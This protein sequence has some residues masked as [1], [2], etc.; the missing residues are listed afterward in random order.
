ME[1]TSRLNEDH[2]ALEKH[3][4]AP[5]TAICIRMN[6]HQVMVFFRSGAGGISWRLSI[7]PTVWSLMR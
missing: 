1:A 3:A 7:V 2:T 5:S 4:V 6:S